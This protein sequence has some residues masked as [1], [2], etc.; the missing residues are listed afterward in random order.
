MHVQREFLKLLGQPVREL[1]G[2]LVMAGARGVLGGGIVKA[3]LR[4]DLHDRQWTVVQ[5]RD[6]E[7]PA[8]DVL[9]DQRRRAV[10]ERPVGGGP[11]GSRFAEWRDPPTGGARSQTR[12]LPAEWRRSPS[13]SAPPRPPGRCGA[14][15]PARR[16][17]LPSAPRCAWWSATSRPPHDL[18]LKL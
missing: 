18:H 6:R 2:N 16:T 17:A 15:S 8:V 4:D 14:R 10:G 13:G 7:F 9:L 11:E 3:V 1:G 12:P 5:D